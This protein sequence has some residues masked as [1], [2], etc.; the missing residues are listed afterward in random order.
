MGQVLAEKTVQE[1]KKGMYCKSTQYPV[2]DAPWSALSHW[3][4]RDFHRRQPN[5]ES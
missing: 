4:L 5:V 1:L 3:L 2:A